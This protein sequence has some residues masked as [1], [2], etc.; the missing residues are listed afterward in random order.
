MARRIDLV[1][2]G[3]LTLIGYLSDKAPGDVR[4]VQ[5]YDPRDERTPGSLRRQVFFVRTGGPGD[6]FVQEPVYGLIH[7]AEVAQ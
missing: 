6:P 3:G 1:A 2:A 5:T 4:L 7:E